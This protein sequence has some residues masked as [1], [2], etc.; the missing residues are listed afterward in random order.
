LWYLTALCRR[1]GVRVD[2]IF[3]RVAGGKDYTTAVAA[4]DLLKS[5]ISHVATPLTVPG[6][7]TALLQLGEAAA[8][9]FVLRTSRANA[10]SKLA[11]FV[12][13]YLRALSAAQVTFAEVVNKNI[14]KTTGRF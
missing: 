12:D 11:T 9:L 7:D 10:R 1:L 8:G 6:L 5:P 2:E 4:N 3:G 13:S 14:R